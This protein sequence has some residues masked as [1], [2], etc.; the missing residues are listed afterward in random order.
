MTATSD[1]LTSV[2]PQ[3][4]KQAEPDLR[5]IASLLFT[6]FIC[7]SDCDRDI[8]PQEVRVL[9]RLTMD[10]RWA[11]HVDLRAALPVLRAIYSELW[12]AYMASDIDGSLASVA[13]GLT[14]VV[15]GR[16]EDDAASL[17]DGLLEFIKRFSPAE[18]S[19]LSRGSP[20]GSAMR[21]KAWA[22]VTR[23]LSEPLAT[24][25]ITAAEPP[26]KIA[27]KLPADIV[28]SGEWVRGRTAVRCV[29]VVRETADVKSFSFVAEP[30]CIFRYKPGQFVTFELTIDGRNVRRSYTISS[31][32]S[33]PTILTVTIKRLE[34][35]VASRWLHDTMHEGMQCMVSGPHGD[36]TCINHAT[37]KLLLIAG[38]S[39][40]TPVM[41]MLRYLADTSPHRDICFINS[42]R[43]PEDII[44]K[45]E[46]FQLSAQF[47]GALKL[48]ILPSAHA[49][50][51]GWQ[52]LVG[53]LDAGVLG[54]MVPD[55][56]EREVFTCGPASFMQAVK[57]MLG[58]LGHPPHRYHAESFAPA[59]SPRA[60]PSRSDKREQ[61]ERA[62]APPTATRDSAPATLARLDGGI[63]ADQ[64]A[65]ILFSTSNVTSAAGPDDSILDV[66]EFT[67]VEIRS[68]CRAGVCGT[69][70]VRV[71][72][73]TAEMD[74]QSTLTDDD[75]SKGYILS[76][77]ARARGKVV[78]EA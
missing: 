54:F 26:T 27:P 67:G 61:T 33:R 13:R 44:F 15:K 35:G 43:S 45:R 71:A 42:V 68:S 74:G 16:A 6:L 37:E 9:L 4:D 7:L 29:S 51:H 18:R 76:C 25:V 32:P 31:S 23:L 50:G 8:T 57:D 2:K 47:G 10:A 11:S 52:G 65:S 46:L 66:A 21:R 17:R 77:V 49:R 30:A 12:A 3:L 73:G 39:G 72:S 64:P 5:P 55:V 62:P 70:R 20:A 78:V 38:G 60:L 40:V 53:R 36:F 24:P 56:A 75:L 22:D 58:V 28:A 14:T 1:N 69:C 63:A 48:F 41:S 19:L 34:D 59:A